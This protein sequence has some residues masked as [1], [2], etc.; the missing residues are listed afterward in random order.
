MINM[1]ISWIAM[2]GA[3][4]FGLY[5]VIA[6]DSY[7]SFFVALGVACLFSFMISLRGQL[8]L[9]LPFMERRDELAKT[10]RAKRSAD[11]S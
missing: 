10:A 6:Y 3:G 11:L 7:A 9:L 4:A 1:A 5:H 8:D 2:L